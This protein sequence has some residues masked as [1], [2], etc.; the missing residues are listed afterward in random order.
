MPR[1]LARPIQVA[2]LAA[3]AAILIAGCGKEGSGTRSPDSNTP[4]RAGGPGHLPQGSAP[5]RLDPADFTT[6][7]DNP[8]WP[9]LP[10]SR[11]VYRET[12]EAG[13]RQ[14]VEITVTDK[15]KEV[16]GVEAR[17]IHDRVTEDG[18]LVEDTYDWYA[19]DRAGNIWY[20]GEDTKA[21]KNGRVTTTAGSWEAGV[22]GAQAGIAMPADPRVGMSYRQEYY[23]GEAEDAAK[24]LSL[25]E[26]V[27]VPFG[28]F[29]G[30][31]M[32]KDYTPLEPK[33]LEHKLYA[34]RVGLVLGLDVSGG[35]SREELVRFDKP[36]A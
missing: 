11:W 34:K 13:N 16:A 23:A 24:V 14:R 29:T 30:A 26:Q 33:I 4:G 32:T 3:L 15:K 21:Y 36:G 35:S 10:G 18:R 31:L 1:R 12:D 17:V 22:D 28:H 8:Y 5:V 6:R 27:E 7:I 19:Q 2:S 9:M 25:E 20:L